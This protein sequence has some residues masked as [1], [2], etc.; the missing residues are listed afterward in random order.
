MRQLGIGEIC[1]LLD[2]KP[3]VLRY[4]EQE[5]SFLEPEKNAGGRRVY[6]DRELNLLYRLKF[7][8]SEKRLTVEGAR[9]ALLDEM[10]G[11]RGNEKAQILGL[12]RHLLDSAGALKR[13]AEKN[14]ELT[15]SSFIPPGQGHL[16]RI[17]KSLSRRRRRNMSAGF[18]DLSPP[19]L[20]LLMSLQDNVLLEEAESG[21]A[22]QAAAGVKVFSRT[23]LAGR[24]SVA[25]EE[26]LAAG[27]IGLVTL[28]PENGGLSGAVLGGLRRLARR[29][30]DVSYRCGT[31][32]CWYIFA[33]PPDVPALRL[34]LRGQDD[35]F[36]D[37]DKVFFLREPFFPYLDEKK[38]L[39]VQE[40]GRI[41]GYASGVAGVLLLLSSPAFSTELKR[42]GIDTLCFLPLNRFSLNFPDTD[43]LAGHYER[44]ADLSF[45]CL[46]AGA[47]SAYL[48]TGNYILRYG[49]LGSAAPSQHL[50]SALPVTLGKEIIR[51][52]IPELQSADELAEF[53]VR[54]IRS[55]LS[56]FAGRS[57]TVWGIREDS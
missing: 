49:F 47:G 17:W 5:I 20:A 14:A 12:R 37:E 25:A 27:R 50:G 54:R 1:R 52:L 3:H 16:R 51:A 41:A 6:G 11:F 24:D 46:R 21:P 23:G 39:Y 2:I 40:D 22:A 8:I 15:G 56:Y 36:Y 19:L 29:I 44:R 53:P 26:S 57:G 43:M 18:L 9:L 32:P 34:Q 10:S 48:T 7:L 38:C 4:W 42:R 35:F 13:L 30:R 28:L 55:S 45:L 31:I 33:A